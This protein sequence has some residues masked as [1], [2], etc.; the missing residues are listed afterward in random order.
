MNISAR[1]STEMADLNNAGVYRFDDCS[2]QDA[3]DCPP[4][5]SRIEVM[6]VDPASCFAKIAPMSGFGTVGNPVLDCP[7]AKD[8]IKVDTE[9]MGTVWMIAEW[10]KGLWKSP[11]KMCYGKFTCVGGQCQAMQQV[12]PNPHS[13]HT[14]IHTYTHTHTHT[15]IHTH[16]KHTLFLLAWDGGVYENLVLR[17]E[18]TLGSGSCD[19][20]CKSGRR[21]CCFGTTGTN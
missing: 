19:G 17:C 8:T 20:L 21:Y 14:H 4:A 13:K 16:I 1:P 2:C 3:K 6:S 15:C 7:N 5:E 18:V 11:S 12:M 9:F 10:K